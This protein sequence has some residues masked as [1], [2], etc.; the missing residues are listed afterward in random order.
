MKNKLVLMF[1]V[2]CVGISFYVLYVLRSS[3]GK[4]DA[5]GGDG[6]GAET[7]VSHAV[8][9]AEYTNSLGVSEKNVGFQGEAS[10]SSDEITV[11]ELRLIPGGKWVASRLP[12]KDDPVGPEGLGEIIS[13]S[14][15]EDD[16]RGERL[17]RVALN[18]REESEVRQEAL[19]QWLKLLPEEAESLLL[20]L[21]K[22]DRLS[23]AMGAILLK[24]ALTRGEAIQ[25]QLA[26]TLLTQAEPGLRKLASEQL[27][28][29]TGKDHGEDVVAWSDEIRLFLAR[30]STQP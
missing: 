6:V 2:C 4:P 30:S 3:E 23:P 20:A 11:L 17:A 9:S 29:I 26:C 7:A 14:N 1:L 8:A 24:D 10:P 19:D 16:F 27:V 5:A 25:L 15:M 22:D 28:L 12:I 13:A 18:S 21:A